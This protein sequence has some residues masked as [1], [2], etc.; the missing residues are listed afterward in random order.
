MGGAGTFDNAAYDP[1][2]VNPTGALGQYAANGTPVNGQAL[3]SDGV[4]ITDPGAFGGA[5]QNVNYEQVA[6]VKISTSSFSAGD[7]AWADC[8]QRGG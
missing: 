6:E 5:L 4:D 2:Q 8:D 7:G 1:S 3:L